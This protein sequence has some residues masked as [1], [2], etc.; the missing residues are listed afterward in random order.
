MRERESGRHI[1]IKCFGDRYIIMVCHRD[2]FLV[3]CW[4]GNNNFPNCMIVY[5]KW[6]L[7]QS[8][9]ENP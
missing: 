9:S 1:K 4:T 8:V 6:A 7:N 3:G 5:R 2:T